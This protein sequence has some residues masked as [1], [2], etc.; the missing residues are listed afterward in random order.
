MF[1]TSCAGEQGKRE[2]QTHERNLTGGAERKVTCHPA[3]RSSWRVTYQQHDARTRQQLVQRRGTEALTP[4]EGI[5]AYF[6]DPRAFIENERKV[7]YDDDDQSKDDANP[8][9]AP[10]AGLLLAVSSG[11]GVSPNARVVFGVSCC[12]LAWMWVFA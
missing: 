5:E 12:A 10:R 3:A 8:K 2:S 9:S 4:A 11:A 1:L 6:P 7:T